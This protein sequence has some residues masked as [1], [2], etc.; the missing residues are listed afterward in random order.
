MEEQLLHM[1]VDEAGTK[2]KKLDLTK[3]VKRSPTACGDPARKRLHFN[4][5]SEH[6]SAASSPD[7]LGPPAKNKTA[8]A[9]QGEPQRKQLRAVM[10]NS[11][12]TR[13]QRWD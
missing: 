2:D 9:V 12:G 1:Q 4:S 5:E 13:G 6:S 3:K 7:H 10:K 8:A 11:K